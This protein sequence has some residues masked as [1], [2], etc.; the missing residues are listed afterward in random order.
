MNIFTKHTKEQGV[1]YTEH[2]FF[3]TG[4]AVRLF[5]SVLAFVLHGIFPFIDIRKEL[6]LEATV[7]YLSE[8][9]DWI[10]GMKHHKQ[11]VFSTRYM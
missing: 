2:L 6:D 7:E 4:I 5:S 3:A 9:N 11:S 8:Q 10:E 1:S